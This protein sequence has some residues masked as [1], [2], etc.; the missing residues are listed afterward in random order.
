MVPMNRQNQLTLSVIIGAVF[1]FAIN[2][3]LIP[4][5]YSTGVAVATVLTEWLVTA[6]Q[7][8]LVRDF[9]DIRN[10]FLQG[11]RYLLSGLLMFC[12][13]MLLNKQLSPSIMHTGVIIFVGS[14]V[15]GGILLFARDQMVLTFMNKLK[16]KF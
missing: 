13:V 3:Y 5:F 9:F 11:W 6:V 7:F 1:N 14:L 2:F 12:I 4:H 10:I 16:E 15:Y 8:Y